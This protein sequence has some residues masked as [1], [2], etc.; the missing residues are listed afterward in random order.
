[1]KK[2]KEIY[3]NTKKYFYDE[4]WS[5]NRSLMI[6]LLVVLALVL[7]V[8][9]RYLT[10]PFDRDEGEY[11]YMGQLLLQGHLPYEEAYNLK[12]PGTYFVFALI[13][14]IF[15]QSHIAVHF[16]LLLTVIATGLFML[17][18]FKNIA[19]AKISIIATTFFFLM[20][21]SYSLQGVF[22]RAEHFV[23]LFALA[24]LWILSEAF[25]KNKKKMFF[26][27]F[28]GG[29]SLSL[30]FIM[31]QHGLFFTLFGLL[32]FGRKAYSGLMAKVL[33]KKEFIKSFIIYFVGSIFPFLILI[34]VYQIKGELSLLWFWTFAYAKEHL[35][36]MTIP[37]GLEYLRSNFFLIARVHPFQTL[38][39]F[40]GLLAVL[41]QI[42]KNKNW[43]FLSF[44]TASFLC[45]VPGFYFSKYYFN[46]FLPG[47][48]LLAA[49]GAFYLAKKFAGKENFK[50]ALFVVVL[51]ATLYP[52]FSQSD[53]LFSYSGHQTSRLIFGDNPFPEAM[54]IADYLKNNTNSSDKIAV[55]G[56][57]PEI[58]FYTKR[59]SATGFIYMYSLMDDQ[60]YAVQMQN[61]LIQEIESSMPKYI[62]FV[63]MDTS[64]RHSRHKGEI[65][66]NWY[67]NFLKDNYKLVG[68][69]DSYARD[70]T[71][72]IW[73]E[74]ALEYK[75]KSENI[76]WIYEKKNQ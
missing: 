14:L 21:L 50:K 9:I 47:L 70:K 51:L 59:K 4:F 38:L 65:I 24:G 68:V 33:D 64:W 75:I 19:N 2:I 61:Q 36:I 15:G 39:F 28:I 6:L 71:D 74:E 43:I 11:A 54:V 3:R 56:S 52:V 26:M 30:S 32:Y 42:R 5:Q 57:E 62:V 58:F 76:V 72:Y 34:L 46:M 69:A 20:S 73:G 25:G 60:K 37:F 44:A 17:L 16:G 22:A 8:R 27:F 18:F 55:L 53:Y 7:I 23:V 13:M 31:K 35:S 67:P 63:S 40:I 29:F 41:L 49:V 48:C 10:M 12:L 1:M 45:I 66:I